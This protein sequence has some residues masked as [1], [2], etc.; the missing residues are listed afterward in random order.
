MNLYFTFEYKKCELITQNMAF[1]NYDGR[2]KIAYLPNWKYWFRY[3]KTFYD[4]AFSRLFCFLSGKSSILSTLG[5]LNNF[6][7]GDEPLDKWENK[8]TI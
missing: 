1:R 3:L 4:W 5:S 8:G 7:L 6:A 2:G